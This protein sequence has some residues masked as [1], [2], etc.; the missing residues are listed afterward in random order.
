MTKKTKAIGPSI[1]P[2]HHRS[3]SPEQIAQVD[4]HTDGVSG[5]SI[6]RSARL[7]CLTGLSSVSVV[8]IQY[9][10]HPVFFKPDY[11]REAIP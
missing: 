1:A 4:G 5:V 6:S 9:P 2:E 10:E 8:D 3:Q 11:G 7:A